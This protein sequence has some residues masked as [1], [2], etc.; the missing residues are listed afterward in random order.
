MPQM[1]GRAECYNCTLDEKAQSMQMHA[2]IPNTWWEFCV[3]HGNYLYNHTPMC[4]LEWKSPSE[5]LHKEKPDLS[6]LQILGC[7]DYIFIPKD[8]RKNKLSPKCPTKSKV[9]PVTRI[10]DKKPEEPVVEI[11]FEDLPSEDDTFTPP[12]IFPQ[13]DDDRSHDN[14]DHHQPP[15]PPP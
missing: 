8:V 7:G 2:C 10:R 9:P 5:E 4:R 1:N 6:H 12:P 13:G 11:E 3:L 14:V 15:R